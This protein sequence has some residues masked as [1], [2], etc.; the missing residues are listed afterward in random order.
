MQPVAN[1]MVIQKLFR[2]AKT[3][4]ITH[5][6]GLLAA[7]LVRQKGLVLRCTA[8]VQAVIIYMQQ[9]LM[10]AKNIFSRQS[11]VHLQNLFSMFLLYVL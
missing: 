1:K 11:F 2:L 6:D 9:T 8:L 10:D 3:P 5:S 4:L 7:R